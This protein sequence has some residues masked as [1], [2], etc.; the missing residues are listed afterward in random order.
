MPEQGYLLGEAAAD[1]AAAGLLAGCLIAQDGRWERLDPAAAGRAPGSFRGATLDSRQVRPGQLFVA[2]AGERHDGRDHVTEALTGGAFAL[3]RSWA[4]PGA[5]PLQAGP[6]P[7]RGAVLLSA[8]PTAALALLASRW[9]QRQ[10]VQVTAVTGSNGKTTTKDLLAAMFAAAGPTWATAGNL[11]NE[12]GL[13]LTLLGLRAEH[14]YAAVELGASAVGDIA[15][16][17]ALAAPAVGVITNA[18]EAHLA[19]FGSLAGVIQGK[20]EL[21]DALPPAGVAVLNA[22]SPGFADWCRRV[23]CRVVSWGREG[24]DFRW[25]WRPGA[26]GGRGQVELDGRS[27]EV[28]LPGLHNG[29]NLVAAVLAARAAGLS[30]TECA[31]GLSAF[32]PSAHRSRLAGIGPLRVLDDCYNANPTSMT[33]AAATLVALPGPGKKVAVLGFMA[34][35]GSESEAIHR[36]TGEELQQLGVDQL[37]AVGPGTEPLAAG[38]AAAG[39]DGRHFSGKAEAVAWLSENCEEGTSLLVKGSRVAAME[40]VIELLRGVFAAGGRES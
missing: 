14:E 10:P 37:V 12:L 18:A 38:F 35:L 8:D 23:R 19:E 24:G 4:D 22:D 15:R 29:A 16:L 39:G 25:Q 26:E 6:A 36:R 21:L 32:S 7:S 5:D 3:T 1:L 11:N 9:R 34:E 27:W 20:G 13:P 40:E 33:S 28:P 31:A 17:A 2:L 30:E